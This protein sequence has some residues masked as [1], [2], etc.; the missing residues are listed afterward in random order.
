MTT[1]ERLIGQSLAGVYLLEELIASGSTS[2]VFRATNRRLDQ[3]VAV[4]VLYGSF[5]TNASLMS[6]F[7][8]EA[9]VQAQLNHP[10]IVRVFDFISDGGTYAM[11][12]ELVEGMVLDQLLYDVAGPLPPA[13]IKKLVMPVLDALSY[14]HSKGIVHRDVKPSNIIITEVDGRDFPKVMDFGIAKVLAEGPSNT[15]PGAMLGTLLFMSPEQCKALKTVDSRADIYSLG[16]TLYQMT[17]GMV[18]FYA[19]SA[20]EIMLAHVQTPPTPPCELVPSLDPKMEALIL[21]AL[22]KDAED[23]YQTVEEL[24]EALK[25]I[26]LDAPST[27]GGSKNASSKEREPLKKKSPK[28]EA[29]PEVRVLP[30]PTGN[31][32]ADEPLLERKHEEA[33]PLDSATFS[34]PAIPPRYSGKQHKPV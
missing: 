2:M 3:P 24:R 1:A 33:P 5:T 9:R 12:M 19:E 4:K 7:E 29:L 10:H 23:R 34:A 16:V 18:P 6:R 30:P 21:K 26:D 14:A 22:S 28:P 32:G 27:P 25:A 15:A 11:V 13:R 31:F 17:T 20:F 8:V